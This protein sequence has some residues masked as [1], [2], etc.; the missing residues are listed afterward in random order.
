MVV[1]V[2]LNVLNKGLLMLK[3]LY[4]G[5]FFKWVFDEFLG[6]VYLCYQVSIYIV[7]I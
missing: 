5:Y 7:F 2:L 3:T 1:F 4:K 6:L